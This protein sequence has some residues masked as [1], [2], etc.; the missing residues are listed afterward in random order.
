MLELYHTVNS[1]CAQKIRIQLAEKKLPWSSRIMT[2]RGDQFEPGYL[3]LNP[4]GVVPTLVH[5][6]QPVAYRCVARTVGP[7]L[8]PFL[9]L[10][11]HQLI[12]INDYTRPEFRRLGVMGTMRTLVARELVAQGFRESWTTELPTNYAT[13]SGSDRTG[14]E[15]ST[16]IRRCVLGHVRFSVIPAATLSA[17]PWRM[18]LPSSI[19]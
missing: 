1:V 6:G 18:K 5:D 7:F 17:G 3:K 4:N 2:L 16:L 8:K 14:I 12:V 15:R 9:R 11:P 10:R 13:L 19:T